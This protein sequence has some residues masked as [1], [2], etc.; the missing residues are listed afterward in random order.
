MH[1]NTARLR[2]LILTGA[3]ALSTATVLAT[4]GAAASASPAPA[5]P[6]ATSAYTSQCGEPPVPDTPVNDGPD[7]IFASA[8]HWHDQCYS[9]GTTHHRLDCDTIFGVLLDLACTNHYWAVD[10]RRYL[11]YGWATGYVAAVRIFGYFYWEGP[12]SWNN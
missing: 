5:V 6:A 7:H 3:A 4:T 11:C 12:P 9:P 2:I 10:P 1:R 8:C